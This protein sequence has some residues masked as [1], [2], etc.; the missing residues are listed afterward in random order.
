MEYKIKIYDIN[1]KLQVEVNCDKEG[2]ID[3][4][5][6][7]TSGKEIITLIIQNSIIIINSIAQI[8]LYKNFIKHDWR[9]LIEYKH[10]N[11]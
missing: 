10:N 1:N 7:I 6:Q 4:Y 8:L 3:I 2:A 9:A 11:N 5:N